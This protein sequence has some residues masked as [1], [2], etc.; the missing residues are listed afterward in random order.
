MHQKHT[1]HQENTPLPQKPHMQ[2]QNNKQKE[3]YTYGTIIGHSTHPPTCV[4]VG[5][6]FCLGL[7]KS[8]GVFV[9]TVIFSFIFC[10]VHGKYTICIFHHIHYIWQL[11]ESLQLFLC[12]MVYVVV[13]VTIVDDDLLK[14]HCRVSHVRFILSLG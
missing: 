1:E 6:V 10:V 11:P 2:Q 8:N 4:W 14:Q 7:C 13:V 5:W 12:D 9:I 3:T